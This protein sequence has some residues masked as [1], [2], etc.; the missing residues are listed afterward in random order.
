MHMY[1]YMYMYMCRY[2]YRYRSAPP[3]TIGLDEQ[4]A[5]FM[6]GKLHCYVFRVLIYKETCLENNDCSTYYGL[7][8]NICDAVSAKP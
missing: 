1:L 5:S 6:I 4:T 7:L 8:R 3:I 2:R